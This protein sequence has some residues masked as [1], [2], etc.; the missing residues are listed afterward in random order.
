MRLVKEKSGNKGKPEKTI[1]YAGNNG[2]I[3][4]FPEP[5]RPSTFMWIYDGRT[6]LSVLA[7]PLPEPYTHFEETFEY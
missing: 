3:K 7:P 6:S 4:Y 2:E 1:Q 5:D